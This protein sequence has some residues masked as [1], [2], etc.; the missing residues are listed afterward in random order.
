MEG[1]KVPTHCEGEHG[2][3]S[4]VFVRMRLRSTDRHALKTEQ[5]Q[6]S[7]VKLLMVSELCIVESCSV[8]MALLENTKKTRMITS[9]D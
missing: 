7:Q 8:V 6:L 9:A 2:M 4:E 3:Q 5:T 1:E